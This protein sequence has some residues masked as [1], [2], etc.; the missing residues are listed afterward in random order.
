MQKKCHGK[1]LIFNPGSE[2]G[3]PEYAY[4]QATALKKLGCD[5]IMLGDAGHEG[6]MKVDFLTVKTLWGGRKKNRRA[7]SKLLRIGRFAWPI[8]Y[9]EIILTINTFIYRPN[10]VLLS[11]YE[12]YLSPFWVWLRLIF[13][14]LF[15]V[16][17]VANLHDPVRDF[18]VGPKWWHDLSVWTAYMPISAVFVHQSLPSQAQVPSRILVRVV[19]HG[20]FAVAQSELDSKQIRSGWQVPDHSIVF[21][22]FGFIRDGKNLDLLIR[23]LSTNPRAYLV[24]IGRVQSTS[25]NKPVVYYESLA[26]QLALTNRVRFFENFVPNEK[27]GSYFAAADVI[28]MTYSASFHSQSGVLNAIATAGKPLLVSAGDSP[29]KDCVLRFQLGV[30]VEPDNEQ[31]LAEGMKQMCKLVT[32]REQGIGLT[33]ENPSLDWDGYCRYASWEVNASLVVEALVSLESLPH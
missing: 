27:L 4:Y 16:T 17:Y 8:L 32:K 1:V 14:Q 33:E 3:I 19:P 13:K 29:L 18:I 6:V 2:G 22:S 7:R 30:L 28:A 31:A 20:L 25:I 23:A 5:I 12:E 9:N 11:S 10:V 15:N 21:L 26:E 24:V